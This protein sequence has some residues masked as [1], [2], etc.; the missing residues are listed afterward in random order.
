[1]YRRFRF[2]VFCLVCLL[3]SSCIKNLEEEGVYQSTRFH[4]VVMD[5]RTQQPLQG[6]R[7]AATDGWNVG[8]V[9]YTAADGTFVIDVTLEQ[10][11][12]NYYIRFESDSLYESHDYKISDIT[13]GLKEY[14]MGTI[15]LEG[16]A[17]PIV[18]TDNIINITATSAHCFGSVSNDGRSNITEQGF[19]YSTMQ[20][21]TI[22]NDKVSL[23][24]DFNEFD[25]ELVLEP[26][27]I[28]YVRAYAVNSIGVGYGDQM[29]ITTL[30]GLAVVSTSV[31]TNVTTTSATCGGIVQSDGGFVVTAR[32]VCWSTLADPTISNSHTVDGAGS[33]V[34]TSHIDDLEPNTTYRIRAYAQ[35]ASGISYGTVVTFTTQSG[36]PTVY[37]ENVTSI[38]ATS[39]TAGGN[40]VDDGGY[41]VVRRGVC[42]GTSSQPTILGLHTTDGAGTGRYV[43]Q[44]T[45]LTPG[46]TYYY[47]AYATNGVGTVYGEQKV[48]VAW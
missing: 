42:Y 41:P 16:P 35:N 1:M 31:V 36:L 4:G 14:D 18:N 21:P 22:N 27:T 28:Y 37:T 11:T 45:N 39:A 32:G 15:Y 10:I 7:V 2:L 3:F 26:H 44:L 23:P 6:F 33:G 40:V 20:Y 43:S 47:R 25:C 9:V 48:F 12:K 19:V 24:V 5:E 29:M 30:D 8:N 34:F 38:S 13:L 17:I 46:S